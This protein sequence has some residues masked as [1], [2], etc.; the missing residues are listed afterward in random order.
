MNVPRCWGGGEE[1]GGDLGGHQGG[2]AWGGGR[3]GTGGGLV[4]HP[5]HHRTGG[6]HL[7]KKEGNS[8]EFWA[9]LLA[10][11]TF[12]PWVRWGL[13][14]MRSKVRE[15]KNFFLSGAIFGLICKTTQK[16]MNHT[17]AQCSCYQAQKIKS[18]SEH[19]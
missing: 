4:L 6:I 19:N 11:H 12:V 13:M 18:I 9:F 2:G 15:R 7:R 16:E 5:V 10:G 1:N 14:G 3:R 8:W 17:Q